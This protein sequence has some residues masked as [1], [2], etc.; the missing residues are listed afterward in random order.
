MDRAATTLPA[1]P[2]W[3]G[4]GNSSPIAVERSHHRGDGSALSVLFSPAITEI[5]CL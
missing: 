2:Q 4:V 3:I 5:A 1:E